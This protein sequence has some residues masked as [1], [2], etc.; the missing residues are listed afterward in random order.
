MFPSRDTPNLVKIAKP[1]GCVSFPK[2]SCPA[3]GGDFTVVVGVHRSHSRTG[4]CSGTLC[5]QQVKTGINV[6]ANQTQSPFLLH[7]QPTTSLARPPVVVQRTLLQYS[8][9]TAVCEC[10]KTVEISLHCLQITSMKKELGACTN[11]LSLCKCSSWVGSAFKRSIS[12]VLWWFRLIY[13]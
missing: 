9:C 8:H 1:F 3:V 2:H 5:G 11:L 4:V 10:E 6:L 13:I 12:I 7:E